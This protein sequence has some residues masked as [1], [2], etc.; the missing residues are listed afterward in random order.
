MI[1][2]C[3]VSVKRIVMHTSIVLLNMPK[4]LNFFLDRSKG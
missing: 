4:P 1:H 3:I 2:A